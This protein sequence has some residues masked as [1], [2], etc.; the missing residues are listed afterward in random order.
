[1]KGTGTNTD[2]GK[3]LK[4]SLGSRVGFDLIVGFKLKDLSSHSWSINGMWLSKI[5]GSILR[6]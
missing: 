4:S 6:V 5:G 3:R 1:M 2:P